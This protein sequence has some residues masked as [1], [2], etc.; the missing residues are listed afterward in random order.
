MADLPFKLS[1]GIQTDPAPLPLEGDELV[2]FSKRIGGQWR[3]V[4]ATAKDIADLGFSQADMDALVAQI[5]GRAPEVH[6]HNASDINAG[7]FA[8]ERIPSLPI[9][10]ITDLTLQLNGKSATGHTHT[11]LEVSGLRAELD[12]LWAAGG[13][14]GGG[15]I[16]LPIAITD[17]S[18]LRF[19]LDDMALAIGGRAFTI[20]Y[21]DAGDITS[22]TLGKARLPELLI[23]DVTGL[24]DALDSAGGG[25]VID[26]GAPAADKVWSSEKVST[27]LSGKKDAALSIQTVTSA[28]TVT[29][30]YT[31]DVVEVTAQAAALAIA[32]PT[33]TAVNGKQFTL[34]VKDDGTVR[35]ITWGTEY[36]GVG[37]ALPAATVAGKWVYARCIRNG[38][39]GKIDVVEAGVEGQVPSSGGTL[40]PP[41]VVNASVTLDASHLNRIIEHNDATTR[42]YTLPSGIG[43]QGDLIAIVNNSTASVT[44]QRSG[45][46]LYKYGSNSNI[47]IPARRSQT[48]YLSG[49]ANTWY[50]L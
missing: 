45:T 9:S 20:H 28:A 38:T 2:F 24:Q 5:N 7:V 14:G 16:S 19:E 8:A 23:A 30:T 41:V 40:L 35:A 1:E 37:V 46:S 29:P 15:G 4:V 33:G 44:I 43:T 6:Q 13:G 26:D 27:S 11:I 49:T 12:D 42:T 3:S 48:I 47:T 17:V 25:A 22:G 21:H 36:V 39:S 10:K 31:N 18:G 32:N 50:A 34:R